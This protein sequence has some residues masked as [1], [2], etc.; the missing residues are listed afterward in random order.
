MR[1]QLLAFAHIVGK[2]RPYEQIMLGRIACAQ[3][4]PASHSAQ[5]FGPHYRLPRPRTGLGC[6]SPAVPKPTSCAA[7]VVL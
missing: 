4:A 2:I 7:S 6:D 5:R 1:L 3:S